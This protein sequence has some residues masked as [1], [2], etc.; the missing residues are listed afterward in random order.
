M[1]RYLVRAMVAVLTFSIGL[2]VGRGPHRPR[3]RYDRCS[4]R[5]V[6]NV[7]LFVEKSVV[8]S[9]PGPFVSI[10]TAQAD[11]LK[12]SYSSTVPDQPASGT[13]HVNFQVD[14]F[15]QRA[16]ANYTVGYQSSVGRH[17]PEEVVEVFVAKSSPSMEFELFTLQ[18]D[19][20]ETLTVWVAR[21]Q[22]KDGSTW[23][24]PRHR[25]G[26]TNL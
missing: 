11:P 17:H 8:A 19:S 24:N 25:V 14:K 10:D 18:C 5:K 2:A 13:Q 9:Y 16:I 3:H 22:F 4:Y 7:R 23:E 15:S 12:L 26:Q 6:E 21:V 20:R 1:N